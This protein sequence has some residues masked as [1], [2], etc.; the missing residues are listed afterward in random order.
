MPNYGVKS[1]RSNYFYYNSGTYDTPVWTLIDRI[2]DLDRTNSKA[3]TNIDMRAS[4]T[5]IT[6][7]G[8]KA[9]DVSFTYYKKQGADDAVF[10]VLLDSYENDTV[11]DLVLA[12]DLIATI[13]TKY[14]RGPFR[15]AE[16]T[17]S[18]PIAGVDAFSI[19]ANVADD[20]HQYRPY[21]EVGVG[22]GGWAIGGSFIIP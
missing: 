13:G 1:G 3:S 5:T 8:N 15:I 17:K 2:G 6:V 14:D 19:K 21:L 11:L 16:M 22:V 12:E 18:E 7:F 10:N 20:I 9:R 4:T